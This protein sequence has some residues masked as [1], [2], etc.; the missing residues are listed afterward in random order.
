[1]FL[2]NVLYL[3]ALSAVLSC[4]APTST[5]FPT[6]HIGIATKDVSNTE[7]SFQQSSFRNSEPPTTL[8]SPNKRDIANEIAMVY[9]GEG[10][11]GSVLN[12]RALVPIQVATKYLGMC[13]SPSSALTVNLPHN[14]TTMT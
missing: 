6:L 9:L 2:P 14:K 1:M 11:T 8:L 10:W 3:S 13:V 12:Y 5:A 4:I 7:E